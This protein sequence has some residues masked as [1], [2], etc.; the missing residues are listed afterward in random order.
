MVVTMM[1][2][3]LD[4][5]PWRRL[6]KPNPDKAS[7]WFSRWH[8]ICPWRRATRTRR[9]MVTTLLRCGALLVTVLQPSLAVAQSAPVRKLLATKES[10]LGAAVVS[11]NGKWLLYQKEL[12]VAPNNS[13]FWI[14]P[15]PDGQSRRLLPASNYRAPQLT[16]DGKRLL[17]LST[18]LN[19]TPSDQNLYVLS[20]PF[21]ESSGTLTGPLRQVTLDAVQAQPR[22][23][24]RVSP[25]GAWLVYTECCTTGELRIVPASG[26]NTRT[27]YKP[28]SVHPRASAF[29]LGWTPDS[30]SVLF[31]VI[32]GDAF[33]RIRVGIDG[34]APVTLGKSEVAIGR[35][36]TDGKTWVIYEPGIDRLHSILRFINAD[37]SPIGEPM[38]LP[39]GNG[40]ALMNALVTNRTFLVRVGD[41]LA[42]LTLASTNGG[43]GKEVSPASEYHWMMGWSG[44]GSTVYANGWL[45]NDLVEYKVDGKQARKWSPPGNDLLF[46]TVSGDGYAFLRTF[47]SFKRSRVE[48][49]SMRLSDGK[50]QSLGTGA[51]AGGSNRGAGGRYDLDGNRILIREVVDNRLQLRSVSGDGN[52]TVILDVPAGKLRNEFS[53]HGERVIF[54]EETAD[55][56]LLRF[57]S[58]PKSTPKTVATFP[59][60]ARQEI[61]WSH[62]GSMLAITDGE[63]GIMFVPVAKDGTV[64]PLPRPV[65]LPFSYFYEPFWLPDGSGVTVIAQ[66]NGSTTTHV[67]LIRV[68]DPERPVILTKEDTHDKWGHMVSPDGRYV[69]YPSERYQGTTFWSVDLDEA[70]RMAKARRP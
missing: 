1:V 35:P 26:G 29:S 42:P 34:G 69:V 65:T 3:I 33:S 37:G 21:D 47:R 52:A 66:P 39:F 64:G 44:D 53:V 18:A 22:H 15:L 40:A 43:T 23:T 55:S 41:G 8:G 45:S 25:D 59:R 31:Q 4:H 12:N 13:E 24:P 56:L 67:V 46:T 30:R 57:S 62:D 10:D 6:G 60:Q 20:A 32:D 7:S 49:A 51:P 2:K 63:H 50:V 48:Y 14:R 16:P 61:A 5:C 19:R 68:A 28:A 54:P 11:L 36:M 70:L 58:G 27:I 38:E 17:I 9:Q